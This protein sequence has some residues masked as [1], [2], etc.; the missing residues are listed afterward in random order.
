MVKIVEKHVQLDFPLG[1]HL[2]CLIA[3]IPNRLQRREHLFSLVNAEEQ[4]HMVRSVLDLVADGAGNL[5]R[6]HFLMFPETSV[7]LSRFDDLLGMIGERFRSN[8]VTMFGME[9]VRLEQYRALLTRFQEDNAEALDCVERDID[10]GDILGMPVNWCCIAIKETS[11]RLRVFLEAKTHPF[12]GEEFLDK[13]HDLYRGR[14][15][16]LFRGEPACFN[17]MAI[18]CLDYLYRDLYSSNI[19]QIIDHAN[20]LFFTMRQSL[21]A[22]FVIQCN[23]KPEHGAY[24]DALS[25]FYGEYLEDTPG[26]RETVTVFG[27]CS[28]ESEIEGVRCQSCYGVSFVAISARHKM[29][30][31]QDREFASDDFDGAPVCRLR[32]GT[33]TRLYYFNL[34]LSHELDP[35]SSRVPLKVHTVLRWTD[36]GWIKAGDGEGQVL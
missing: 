8:T 5:K 12:R 32:F 14:H 23:P 20:R 6:L 9:Q 4:W 13:D 33:G 16:Y 15:F 11:G 17:F 10:S 25:G 26:V 2:H 1:H 7:P 27:N 21:D 28:D 34:P 31:F 24:R 18:I 19:K 30:P 29:S 3:Q 36:E 22:L 35:R